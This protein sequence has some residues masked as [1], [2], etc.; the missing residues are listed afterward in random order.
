MVKKPTSVHRLPRGVS[1]V[2]QGESVAAGAAAICALLARL[3]PDGSGSPDVASGR[4]R[5][6]AGS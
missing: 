5:D 4:E 2:K 3:D 6:K 1:P